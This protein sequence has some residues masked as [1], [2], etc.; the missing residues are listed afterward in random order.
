AYYIWTS[1][2]YKIYTMKRW[3]TR[4]TDGYWENCGGFLYTINRLR[5]VYAG[6]DN[7]T[8]RMDEFFPCH[9]KATLFPNPCAGILTICN[10]PEATV[11]IYNMQGQQVFSDSQCDSYRTFDLGFCPDGLY[12]VRIVSDKKQ[13]ISKLVVNSLN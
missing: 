1:S 2:L 10:I 12:F 7:T 11:T 5:C 3:A 6:V 9:E 13:S 8:T 4:I